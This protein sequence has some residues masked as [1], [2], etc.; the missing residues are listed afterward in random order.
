LKRDEIE[1]KLPHLEHEQALFF[2]ISHFC[3]N[4]LVAW[5]ARKMKNIT[6]SIILNFLPNNILTS[7]PQFCCLIL[8]A[9]LFTIFPLHTPIKLHVELELISFFLLLIHFVSLYLSIIGVWYGAYIDMFS[10]VENAMNMFFNEVFMHAEYFNTMHLNEF[11]WS[12]HH[13]IGK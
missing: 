7:D 6:K 13:L 3:S 1:I 8:H 9:K 5:F 10:V 11:C 2:P 12:T 4:L